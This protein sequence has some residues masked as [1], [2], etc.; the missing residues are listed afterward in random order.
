MPDG[1]LVEIR[2]ALEAMGVGL[3][4]S[5]L[6]ALV[7]LDVPAGDTLAAVLASVRAWVAEGSAAVT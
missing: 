5:P 6:P 4:V 2:F 3:D 7:G 1:C